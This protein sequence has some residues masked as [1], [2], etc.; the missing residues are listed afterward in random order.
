MRW[1]G[2][3]MQ[4]PRSAA[5]LLQRANGLDRSGA[6]C[7]A[8][9]RA[10]KTFLKETSSRG[11]VMG[12]DNLALRLKRILEAPQP[13]PHPTRLGNAKVVDRK[14]GRSGDEQRA[15][16]GVA[17]ATPSPSPPKG[18]ECATFRQKMD[19]C[20][21]S[22]GVGSIT[23]RLKHLLGAPQPASHQA[24]LDSTNVIDRKVGGSGDKQRAE[25]GGAMASPSSSPL[26]GRERGCTLFSFMHLFQQGFV[27]SP[28]F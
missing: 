18:R 16:G 11:R 7:M 20:E 4:H 25:V 6:R 2:R 5:Q 24:R 13:A 12:V 23:L 22:A 28:S 14:V 27:F 3:Q 21:T 10:L 26:K 17:M 1:A 19:I 15:E 9:R 8:I